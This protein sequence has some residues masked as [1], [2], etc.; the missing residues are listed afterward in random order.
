[1]KIFVVFAHIRKYAFDKIF[2]STLFPGDGRL[3]LQQTLHQLR[4]ATGGYPELQ[5]S[6]DFDIYSAFFIISVY[7]S[8]FSG[9]IAQNIRLVQLHVSDTSIFCPCVFLFLSSYMIF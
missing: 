8:Y 7:T 4:R 9:V 5:T 1:M 6:V 3:V 2:I